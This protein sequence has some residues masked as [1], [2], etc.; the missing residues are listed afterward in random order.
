MHIFSPEQITEVNQF[1]Q[2]GHLLAYP[3]EAVWGIGCDP[4]NAKAVQ[5][6]LAI[7]N[8]PIEK[9]MIVITSD[10]DYLTAFLQIL[11][12][13]VQQ[14][15][16]HSWY[17]PH[18]QATTWVLPIPQKL[19]KQIPDWITG[20]R[21]TLA[22]RVIRHAVIMKLCREISQNNPEN[23]FGFLVS[24]SCNQSGKIPAT[25]FQQ[26]YNYFG[27]TVGYLTAQTLGFTQPSQIKDAITEQ[28]FRL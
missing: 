12:N 25:T 8:R 13:N 26:A 17:K 23:P 14:K 24:T 10:S 20:G 2:A 16:I 5:N 19:K 6:I 9:G 3:T 7:K 1:L 22:I 27:D 4:F 15:I 21:E 18:N 11:P 28:A